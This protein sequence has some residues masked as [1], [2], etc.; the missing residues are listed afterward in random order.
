MPEPKRLKISHIFTIS[1]T[2]ISEIYIKNRMSV[3]YQGMSKTLQFPHTIALQGAPTC[4]IGISPDGLYNRLNNAGRL[5]LLNQ[6][7][8]QLGSAPFIRIGDNKAVMLT[9]K[10][11]KVAEGPDDVPAL[12]NYYHPAISEKQTSISIATPLAEMA[13]KVGKVSVIRRLISP[14]LSGNA[15]ASM[16]IGVEEYEVKNSSN[17]HQQIT[18]VIPKPSLVNLQEKELKPTDQDTVYLCSTPVKGHV[19]ADFRSAGMRGW[20]WEARNVRIGWSLLCRKW[21]ALK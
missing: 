14:F 16:P 12:K 13:Y 5:I 10:D 7:A 4:S 17:H 15:Q 19:H 20:S 9:T 18:L 1:G 3:H 8:I 2:Q 11:P 21:K 6:N